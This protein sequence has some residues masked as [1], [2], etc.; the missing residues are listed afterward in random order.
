[1]TVDKRPK[2]VSIV[3]EQFIYRYHLSTSP[4]KITCRIANKWP[5]ISFANSTLLASEFAFP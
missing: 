1:M 5:N 4:M 2:K 3:D